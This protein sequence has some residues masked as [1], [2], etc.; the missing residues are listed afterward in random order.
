MEIIQSNNV[1]VFRKDL[2][3]YGQILCIEMSPFVLSQD[4]IFIGFESKILLGRLQIDVCLSS[5]PKS[6]LT[7]CFRSKWYNLILRR[8]LRMNLDVVR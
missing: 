3:E 4:L 1:R 2:S 7:L 6:Q 5:R 8:N